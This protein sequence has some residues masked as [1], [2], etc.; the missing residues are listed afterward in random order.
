MASDYPESLKGQFLMAMPGLLDPNF[1]QTVICLSEH[2]RDGAVGIVVNRTHPSL[3]AETIFTELDIA[4]H[5][6]VGQVPIYLGGPVHTSEIFIL[7]SRPFDQEI[8]LEITPQLAMSTTREVLESIALAR[9]P[10]AFLISLG[11]AGW[12]PGQLEAEIRQN[13]WLTCT[14][15]DSILFDIPVN[16]RWEGAIRKLGIDPSLLVDAAGNA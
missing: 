11:C 12:G 13:A 7:H 16:Q 5:N 15:D 2:T 8:S 3:K 14:V 4:H 1:H 6:D 10:S 9:G